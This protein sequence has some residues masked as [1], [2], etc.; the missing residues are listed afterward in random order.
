MLDPEQ[1]HTFNDHYLEVDF[2]LSQVMFICTAN[3]LY[4]I[5]PALA[6]RMEIIRLP[7]Y[8]ET[9]KVEIAQEVS[10]FPKQMQ[11]A[12]LE[13]ADLKI[14]TRRCAAIIGRT[15]ARPAC[16]NLEREIAAICRKVARKKAAGAEGRRPTSSRSRSSRRS[17]ASP[18]L[19]SQIERRVPRR[20]RERPRVDRGRRRRAHRRGERP[21][22]ARA[23]SCSPASSAR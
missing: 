19:D 13:P 3:T 21:A 11:G 5:P 17:S 22:R 23:S 16:A 1:N 14:A 4:A 2:D 10:C 20:R 18:F 12:G 8:L 15:R 7:G 6:D 9:E